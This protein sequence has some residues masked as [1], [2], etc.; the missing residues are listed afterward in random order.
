MLSPDWVI[1]TFVS[2]Y[3]ATLSGTVF[4]FGFGFRFRFD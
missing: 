1:L 4:G 3:G 2:F